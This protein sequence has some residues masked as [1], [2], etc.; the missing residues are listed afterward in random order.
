MVWVFRN[1]DVG[2][3]FR[4]LRPRPLNSEELR[5]YVWCLCAAPPAAKNPSPETSLV[6]RD[7]LARRF[8]LRVDENSVL[9]LLKWARRKLVGLSH[10]RCAFSGRNR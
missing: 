8:C 3:S 6:A 4:V 10:R 7:T 1:F 5:F 2:A 9:E